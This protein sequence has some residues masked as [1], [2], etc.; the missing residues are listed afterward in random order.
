MPPMSQC[1]SLLSVQLIAFIRLPGLLTGEEGLNPIVGGYS[2]VWLMVLL[3][4]IHT[5]TFVVGLNSQRSLRKPKLPSASLPEP[6]K[7]QRLPLR[8]VQLEAPLRAPGQFP[9]DGIPSVPYTPNWPF[10]LLPPI[11][12]HWFV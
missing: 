2:P 11:Q 4:P 8:S 10:V 3:P 9:A 5:H 1:R 7:S 6:P 12:V